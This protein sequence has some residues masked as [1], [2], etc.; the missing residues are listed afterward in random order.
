MLKVVVVDDEPIAVRRLTGLLK[1]IDGV[2]VVGTA[3]SS[4]EAAQ[5]VS[6]HSPDLLLLDIEMPGIGGLAFA[7]RIG[8][9]TNA[10]EIIFVTAFSQ[11]AVAAF[12]I[13]V[14]D[15]L[16]KPVDPGRLRLAVQRAQE[17][18]ARRGMQRRVVELEETVRRLHDKAHAEPHALWLDTSR[19]R[20]CVRYP[21]IV[22]IEAERDYVRVHLSERSYF[23]RGCLTDYDRE[24]TPHG[25]ARVHRG[26]IIQKSQ[27]RSIQ[28]DGDRQYR[29]TMCNG[30]EVR[31]SRHYAS[32]VRSLTA[33]TLSPD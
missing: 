19:G 5:L 11:F 31:V 29:L 12:G 16:L 30:D 18:I 4:E 33:S 6:D 13:G 23:V 15:Y 9:M 21:E 8:G 32:T 25:F 1:S 22:W 20:I 10:P 26:H 27:I 14:A 7:D 3:F 2:E 28:S 24:L 17:T